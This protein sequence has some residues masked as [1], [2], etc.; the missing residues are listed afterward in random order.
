MSV[1][2]GAAEVAD[3]HHQVMDYGVFENAS[4]MGLGRKTPLDRIL[5]VVE[6]SST[7]VFGN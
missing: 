1:G 4:R 5:Y 2:S 6:K 3:L 7:S